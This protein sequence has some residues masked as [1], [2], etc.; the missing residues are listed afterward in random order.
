MSTNS[1]RR[2]AVTSLLGWLAGGCGDGSV[3]QSR[4][5]GAGDNRGSGVTIGGIVSGLEGSG[6]EIQTTNGERR[7][8]SSNGEFVAESDVAPGTSYAI[9]IAAQPI[10]PSQT[11]TLTQGT[12]TVGENNVTAI[13]VTC[14]T[15]T[16]T[17]GGTVTGL[18]GPGLQ[19]ELNGG[20]PIA[21]S[22]NG[23]FSFPAL[24][25]G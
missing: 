10:N 4:A 24:P 2:F 12:G 15:N 5:E 18:A 6:L 23:D 3:E 20:T 17:V 9:T 14:V 21:I 22:N 11:C 13:E 16:F 8:V 19:L 7:E 25:D 1:F